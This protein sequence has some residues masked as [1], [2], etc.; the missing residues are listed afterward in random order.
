MIITA[1][2]NGMNR[3]YEIRGMLKRIL[4]ENLHNTTPMRDT[5]GSVFIEKL[6]GGFMNFH[7]HL[8]NKLVINCIVT[9]YDPVMFKNLKYLGIILTANNNHQFVNDLQY[10]IKQFINNTF[11]YRPLTINEIIEM[12]NEQ[13]KI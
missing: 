3:L 2:E 1:S 5:H 9:V 11:V 6:E 10:A 4:F 13:I 12:Y 7:I 8:N